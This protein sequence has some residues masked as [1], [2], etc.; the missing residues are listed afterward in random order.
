MKTNWRQTVSKLNKKNFS[1]PAGWDTREKIAEELEC[2]P[3]RVSDILAPGIRSG[4][5]EKSAFP[6]WDEVL[7]RKVMVVGYRERKAAEPTSPQVKEKQVMTPRRTGRPVKPIHAF[8]SGD[9]VMSRSRK[10]Y[11]TWHDGGVIKWDSGNVSTP[12]ERTIR[13]D[14]EFVAPKNKTKK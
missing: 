13:E 9:R 3:E 6:V 2:S 12:G 5:I 7:Q 1:W 10:T 11:G 8:K 14:I 4:E